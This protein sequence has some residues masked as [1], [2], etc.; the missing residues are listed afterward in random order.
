MSKGPLRVP[1]EGLTAGPAA[2]SEDA[3]AYVVRVHR[4][5]P[6][7]KLVLFDP[8]LGLEADAELVGADKRS[9]RVHV[10]EP[11]PATRHARPIALLQGVGKGDK[12]DAIVR[13][14]TELGAARVIP[15]LCERSIARPDAARSSR[16]RRI[17][18]EAARQ[19][20]RGDAPKVSPPLSLA[21]ALEAVTGSAG[22]CL[23][24]TSTDPLGL[25]LQRLSAR[26]ED[27]ADGHTLPIALLV[28]PEGGLTDAELTQA[29]E[30]GFDRVT[31]GPIVLRT[32]TAGAA[33]LGALL[34]HAQ[35]ALG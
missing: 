12:M 21:G 23:D 1:H 11:R 7:A 4:L 16:W 5:T 35:L 30:A 34:V 28:G 8:E 15:V 32:E 29:Q 3:A 14:A 22:L 13:D 25:A 27:R 20:G 19:S 2:L 9:A 10:F 6:G 26:S 33:V 24:P 18:V 17:A 31:L